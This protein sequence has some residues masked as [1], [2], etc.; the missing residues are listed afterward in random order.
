MPSRQRLR[1]RAELEALEAR[2]LLATAAPPMVQAAL[3]GTVLTIVGTPR[4]DV[5]WL[6]N[7]GRWTTVAG[8][9]FPAAQVRRVI[10]A[11]GDGGDLVLVGR[12]VYQPCFI[13]AGSGND[14][15]RGGAGHDVILGE[16]GND[17]LKGA[18]GNDTLYGGAGTNVIEQG[19]RPQPRVPLSP[20]MREI[21]AL[22]NAERAR[23][24]LGALQIDARLQSA[25]NLHAAQMA[26]KSNAVGP[27]EAAKHTLSGVPY[28][29]LEDRLDHV[30]FPPLVAGENVAALYSSAAQV[31]AAWIASPQH[32]Q[33]MLGRDFT[34]T[35]IGIAPNAAGAT[36]F[37]QDF[38]LPAT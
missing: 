30:G 20:M 6:R 10:I 7:Q 31:V 35:G 5:I 23:H 24:G 8:Q 16:A 1:A 34:M 37:C 15:V 18:A 4:P 38:G 17:T 32:H 3:H 36:F 25:A 12:G 22:V 28:P 9:A 27:Y 26:Q 14:W 19:E 29:S 11:T 33:V 2:L 13:K 21:L